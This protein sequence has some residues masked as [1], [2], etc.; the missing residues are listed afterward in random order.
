[1]TDGGSWNGPIVACN[2]SCV[3]DE[4]LG[5]RP[6]GPT[7]TNLFQ[8]FEFFDV[9]VGDVA[10]FTADFPTNNVIS[11]V[12]GGRASSIFGTIESQIPGADFYLLN[13]SGVD[14]GDGSRLNVPGSF[15]VA[16][17][18]ALRFGDGGVFEAG[19]AA[20]GA[21][22]LASAESFGF[23]LRD[24]HVSLPGGDAVPTEFVFDPDQPHPEDL[25]FE[26]TQ[27]G[28]NGFLNGGLRDGSTFY[29][30]G[31]SVTVLGTTTAATRGLDSN[32][33]QI[34]LGAVA[35]G[36]KVPVDLT[37]LAADAL[38]SPEAVVEV[39]GNGA[40]NVSGSGPD[41]PGRVV[42]RG[43]HFEMRQGAVVA[44][45]QP[46]VRVDEAG[47]GDAPGIDIVAG[48]SIRVSDGQIES[49]A[50]DR[51]SGDISLSA[52]DVTVTRGARISS[53]NRGPF[54][55]PAIEI[56]ADELNVN[57][58][59]EILSSSVG[60][61]AGGAVRIGTETDPVALVRI[62]SEDPLS[63]LPGGNVGSITVSGD[64]GDV[65]VHAGRL[66]VHGAQ[67]ATAQIAALTA[68]FRDARNPCDPN[69]IS[70][71]DLGGPGGD[72]KIRADSI[73][74]NNGGQLRAT[75][76]GAGDA[77][78]IDIAVTGDLVADGTVAAPG[79]GGRPSGIFARSAVF[80]L[81]EGQTPAS[82][83]LPTT[84]D[85]GDLAIAAP[86]L[87]LLDGAEI[88]SDSQQL[89]G[90][91]SQGLAGDLTITADTILV[92][93]GSDPEVFSTISS[94]GAGG[95]GG[96]LEITADRLE[97][98]N[99][100][101]VSASTNGSAAAGDVRVFAH[102]IDISGNLSGI[103][104]QANQAAFGPAGSLTLAP[105]D[106]D[107][108]E[109]RVRDGG[110]VSVEGTQ[111]S[112]GSLEI[113]DAD[114]VEVG[115]G[116][117]ISATARNVPAG[118]ADPGNIRIENAGLVQVLG[119]EI[120]AETNGRA[121]GGQIEIRAD[122]VLLRGGT[123]ESR[124][125]LPP[126]GGQAGDAGD[127]LITASNSFQATQGSRVT[128]EKNNASGG[129]ISIQAPNL[130]SIVDS[131][132]LTEVEAAQLADDAGDI[133]IGR[134]ELISINRSTVSASAR[135]NANAGNIRIA[136]EEVFI[137]A[138]SV[139][140]ATSEVG[141][142]G[143]IDVD[144]PETDI[145]GQLTQLP[146]D[147]VDPSDRLLPPCSARRERTGSFVVQT[148]DA[149]PP[150]PD[151]PLSADPAGAGARRTPN[152]CAVFEESP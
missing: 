129:R 98:R 74:L 30:V 13:P 47:A 6:G 43:G 136:G 106:G 120:T 152:D 72:L 24:S 54:V 148:R 88:A 23:L 8:S 142:D 59:S 93:G 9:G 87:T 82:P 17:A 78:D 27:V 66:V 116:G 44:P 85:A 63:L 95:E 84:G 57:G 141:V 68:R 62:G 94:K 128:T 28:I 58:A 118:Q 56:L 14:F 127:I 75:T 22:Q 96:D 55:G 90:E 36:T 64:G 4:S 151:A 29:A 76:D 134:S 100:G 73:E 70:V 138:D 113:L 110:R 18:D 149:L 40:V 48:H 92:D 80:R 33:G 125:T 50:D 146:S 15:Y 35:S 12:N 2:T 34:Q 105:R 60:G 81:E 31:G 124:S 83:I 45:V 133:G 39:V 130:L 109:L 1:V 67:N 41:G 131:Q 46:L 89:F 25:L 77:G 53:E 112:A 121:P 132:I 101:I 16:T 91:S 86:S 71:F 137:S 147:F 51:A 145:V 139:I 123:I 104:A 143:V 21:M 49:F 140:A 3:I 135:G 79:G 144:A 26:E 150:P 5:F 69:E 126:G 42:I 97:L 115:E 99:G 119:G 114:L 11:A 19:P 122:D 117:L 37:E 65:E 111:G 108:L 10:A 7:G 107:G 61:L 38:D 32:G 102:E 20:A 103:N 52:P